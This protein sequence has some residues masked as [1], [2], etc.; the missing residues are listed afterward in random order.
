M[1]LPLIAADQH[2]ALWA[3]L[4]GL[5]AFGFWC[6]R[7]PWGRKF[8]GVLLLMTA[9][10]ILANTGVLPTV[11][12]VYDQTW[13]LLVPLA[14]P[15]LLLKANLPKIVRE[16]GPMLLAFVISGASVVAGVI[17]GVSLLDLGEAEAELAG[18]FTGTYI[19]GSLNFAAVAEATGFRES[20]LLTA[21]VAA[22][23]VA[24][25]LHYLLIFLLP[26]VSWFGRKYPSRHIR[27]A[28]P[29]SQNVEADRHSIANL[30][31]AGLLMSLAIAFAIA[32]TGMW[33]AELFGISDYSILVITVLAVLVGSL[34]PRQVARL[35]GYEEAG[36]AM[37]YIFL[38]AIGATCDLWLL[39]DMAPVLFGFA[40]II[41]SV[42]LLLL[43]A[44][45]KLL[46]LDLAEMLMAS[47]VAVGGPSSAPALASARGW[48][49]LL[50]PGVLLGCLGYVVGS[51]IGMAVFAWFA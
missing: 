11:A 27:M 30:D 25:N 44:A 46:K 32:A 51:F 18:I 26:G 19:G 37:M 6:E 2:F 13:E 45:G 43:L 35:S 20:S 4:I 47:A 42:H 31:V 5:A 22:D 50:I 41:L 10:I 36:T 48:N 49:S 8:S 9:A 15:L 16:A 3:V 40:V 17:V 29:V 34:L 38:A 39:V 7:Y 12:P 28:G 24:T 14:I 33:L 1:S 23:N 21:A